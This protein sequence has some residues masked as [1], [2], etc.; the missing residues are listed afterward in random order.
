M[1]SA[2]NF[3]HKIQYLGG[4]QNSNSSGEVFQVD[5]A[6]LAKVIVIEIKDKILSKKCI[7]AIVK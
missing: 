2:T 4:C 6:A 1:N 5:S 3:S 7:L